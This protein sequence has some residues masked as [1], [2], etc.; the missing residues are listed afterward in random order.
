VDSLTVLAP[1]ADGRAEEVCAVV[2]ALPSGAQSPFA[3]VFG[4]H[5]ARLT[6]VAAL[7]DRKL[8]PDPSTG[9]FLLFATDLEGDAAAHLERLRNGFGHEA[10]RIW[11]HCAGYPGTRRARAFRDWMLAHRIPTGFSVVPYPRASVQEVRD[12]LAAR[13]R[14]VEFALRARAMD[15]DTLKSEWLRE[16]GDG[17]GSA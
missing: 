2:E 16:F 6:V 15:D 4:T 12:A 17:R 10:D 5:V 3:R 11:G 13:R 14:L 9:S 1:I 8:D 7:E